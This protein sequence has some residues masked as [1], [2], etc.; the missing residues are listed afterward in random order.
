MR[1]SKSLLILS[2]GFLLIVNLGMRNEVFANQSS[3][4][5]TWTIREAELL[6]IAENC[7]KQNVKITKD[8]GVCREKSKTIIDK[9]GYATV[10]GLA[11]ASGFNIFAVAAG[12]ALIIIP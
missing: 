2:L 7:D 9:L 8:L 4:Q 11:V 3:N 5:S 12:I 6:Q 10:G 1:Y